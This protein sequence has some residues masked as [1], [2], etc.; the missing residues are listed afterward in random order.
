M[1]ADGPLPRVRPLLV[2]VEDAVSL[3]MA[4]TDQR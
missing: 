4:K 1:R 3:R 2:I